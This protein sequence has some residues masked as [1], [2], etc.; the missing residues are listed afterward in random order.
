MNYISL[1]I[2]FLSVTSFLKAERIDGPANVRTEPQGL[3]ILSLND[4]VEV[5]CSR[6]EGNWYRIGVNV[7][8]TK[9]QYEREPSLR[10]GDS[11]F[12]WNNEFIGTVLQEIPSDLENKWYSGGAP[13]NPRRYGLKIYAATY[14]S[15]IKSSS[16]PEPALNSILGYNQKELTENDLASYIEEYN[17]LKHGILKNVDSS[18]ME[19][20]IYETTLDDPSPMGRIRLIFKNSILVAVIHTR[21][22]TNKLNSLGLVRGRRI[23]VLQQMDAASEENFIELNRKSFAGVD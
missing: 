20:M 4:N 5:E 12:N 3:T 16:I 17:F 19:Y 22:L 11:L 15:N 18:Y 10:V 7:K 13:G 6:L 2:L 8:I 23:I 9:E 1:I 21:E 14:K